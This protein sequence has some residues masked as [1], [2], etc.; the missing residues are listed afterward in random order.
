MTFVFGSS[1]SQGRTSHSLTSSLLPMEQ[2]LLTPMTPWLMISTR[3]PA[4]S[5]PLW[6]MR[7]TS[8]GRSLFSKARATMKEKMRRLTA[9]TRPMQLG[10]QMRRP[11]CRAMRTR[12]A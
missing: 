4:E 8:P 2:T 10:P 9:S 1:I 5:M 12:S 11:V 6:T 7:E 3:N